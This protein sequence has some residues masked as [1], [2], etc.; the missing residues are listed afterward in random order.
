MLRVTF[1]AMNIMGRPCG[2]PYRNGG[3]GQ[4]PSPGPE[5]RILQQRAG[6]PGRPGAS[7]IG[8]VAFND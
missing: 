7:P 8:R 4:M 6:V 1:Q 2:E 5:C 3:I